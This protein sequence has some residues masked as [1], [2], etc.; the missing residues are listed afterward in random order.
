MWKNGRLNIRALSI[1]EIFRCWA[2]S[3]CWRSFLAVIRY[4]FVLLKV[5]SS[6]RQTWSCWPLYLLRTENYAIWAPALTDERY[7]FGTGSHKT[8]TKRISLLR[9]PKR[10]LTWASPHQISSWQNT[11][12]RTSLKS[13]GQDPI[14]LRLSWQRTLHTWISEGLSGSHLFRSKSTRTTRSKCA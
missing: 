3:R 7:R 14:P 13:N 4:G 2:S 9:L 10:C 1:A 11:F 12:L 5:K 8:F 6:K